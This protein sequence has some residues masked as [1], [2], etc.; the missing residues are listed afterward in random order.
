MMAGGDQSPSA[1]HS[2]NDDGLREQYL[3]SRNGRD[4]YGHGYRD[5]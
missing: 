1:W 4:L 5:G 3:G 2:G